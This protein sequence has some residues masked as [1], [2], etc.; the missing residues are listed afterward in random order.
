MC[1]RDTKDSDLFFL[2][3]LHPLPPPRNR[4][5]ATLSWLSNVR[6]IYRISTWSMVRYVY[7]LL[8]KM[9]EREREKRKKKRV[10]CLT[11]DF[12]SAFLQVAHINTQ[13]GSDNFVCQWQGCKVQGR[14]SCSRRWLERHVLS[15]GGN[16]PFRCI[17]DGCGSRF[18]SQVMPPRFHGK[19]YKLILFLH[20]GNRNPRSESIFDLRSSFRA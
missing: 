1:F 19:K 17:V 12:G 5:I 11:S 3:S 9:R 18:S 2:S 14:S 4:Y 15:H 20:S 7:W 13:T 8:L 16:K 6:W 10:V